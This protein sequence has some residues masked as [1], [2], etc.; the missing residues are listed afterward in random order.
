L[1][2]Y[3]PRN[4]VAQLYLRALGSLFFASYDSQGYGGDILT[5][6]HTGMGRTS[7]LVTEVEVT[8]RPTVGQAVRLGVL[9][10]LEQVTRCYIYLSDDYFLYFSCGALS[11]MRGRVCNLQCNDASS[12]SSYIATDGLS[13][14]S[15]C[16]R[17][18]DG[19]YN[20]ILI[21]S[22]GSYFVFSV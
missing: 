9:S 21:S 14:S 18:P 16:C 22:F 1:Y 13:A 5:R 3:P 20:Q 11:L 19:A 15:S 2:L 8:L 12:I 6:P 7:R 17:A 10:L 4:R